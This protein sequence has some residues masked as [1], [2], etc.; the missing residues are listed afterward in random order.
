MG[1][2]GLNHLPLGILNLHQTV[3]GKD[4]EEALHRRAQGV[5]SLGHQ[6]IVKQF[7][8]NYTETE[9]AQRLNHSLTQVEGYI[10]DFL[11]VC[12]AHRQGYQPE[13]IRHLTGLSKRVVEKHLEH[14]AELSPSPFWQ[15]PLERKLRFYETSLTAEL[16]KKGVLA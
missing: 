6:P 15:E 11:R 7:L 1:K 10:K 8:L 4:L 3:V 16:T 13:G 14:Y 12:V 9:I 5:L 2:T